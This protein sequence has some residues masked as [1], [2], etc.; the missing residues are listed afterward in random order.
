VFEKIISRLLAHVHTFDILANE[1]VGFRPK[2]STETASH[3]LINEVLTAINK[4]KK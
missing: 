1:Q 3:S 4:K 2:R